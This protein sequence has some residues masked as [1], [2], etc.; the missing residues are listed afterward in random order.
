MTEMPSVS[1]EPSVDRARLDSVHS[2][3]KTWT[4]Q[5]V[6]LGGRNNLLYFKDLRRGTLDLGQAAP[7]ALAGLLAGKTVRISQLFTED[8]VREVSRP[9][10]M[11]IDRWLRFGW[12]AS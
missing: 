3:V 4:G 1:V 5:L 8:E 7:K 11:V 6:D 9:M 2:A 12:C 10:S